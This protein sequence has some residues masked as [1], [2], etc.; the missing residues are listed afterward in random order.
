MK[1][2]ITKGI[3]TC[4]L[5]S[6]IALGIGACNKEKPKEPKSERQAM[7]EKD[8]KEGV[9]I[10]EAQPEDS[11]KVYKLR[12]SMKKSYGHVEISAWP[13][14]KTGQTL[15][16]FIHSWDGNWFDKDLWNV[17]ETRLYEDGEVVERKKGNDDYRLEGLKR[18]FKHEEPGMHSYKGEFI[19]ENGVSK[20]TETIQVE[21]TGGILD[22][23]PYGAS[24]ALLRNE[25]FISAHDDG[26]NKGIVHYKIYEDGEVLESKS[27]EP[28]DWFYA[29]VP[30][31]QDKRGKHK[32]YAVFTD[33]GGN[34]VSTEVITIDYD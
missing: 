16:V 23:P 34:E 14:S 11:G 19:Y 24:I 13:E 30:L 31:S 2:T 15:E 9:E 12:E 4:I 1:N 29:S 3:F 18:A 33:R 10:K 25:L 6:T 17:K 32:Y 5:A 28:D 22:L 20:E 7:I 27:W 26:D 8:L 21:F